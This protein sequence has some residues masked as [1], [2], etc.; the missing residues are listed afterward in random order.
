MFERLKRYVEWWNGPLACGLNCG[1]APS[2]TG[3]GYELDFTLFKFWK[4]WHIGWRYIHRKYIRVSLGLLE[5][6][7]SRP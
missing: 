4:A 5:I 3:P 2:P 6:E 7:F 1:Y